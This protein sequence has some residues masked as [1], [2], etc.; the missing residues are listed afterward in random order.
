MSCPTWY[1]VLASIALVFTVASAFYSV[2]TICRPR[3]VHNSL[4]EEQKLIKKVESK[5]RGAIFAGGLIVGVFV[6]IICWYCTLNRE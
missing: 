3:P 1:I 2:M 4:S 5:H 6:A